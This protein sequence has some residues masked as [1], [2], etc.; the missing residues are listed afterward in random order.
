MKVFSSS[1]L[2][3]SLIAV[4]CVS[5]AV[6]PAT[7]SSD[8]AEA[9]PPPVEAGL[10]PGSRL[11]DPRADE[12]VRQMSDLLAGAHSF[13]LEAE[14][15]YDEV[16]EHSPRIQLTNRR[17]VSLRR[18]DRLAG[19]AS[20]DAVNASFWYDGELFSVLDEEQFAYATLPMPPTIDA[21]L[22]AVFERTGIVIPLM[23]FLHDDVYGRLMEAVERGVYLGI[24]EAAG[25]DCHH[26]AFEQETIDWQLWIDAGDVPLPRKLVIAYKTEGGVPQ[27]TVVIREWELGPE[28]P[29]EL[30]RFEPPEGAELLELPG[31]PAPARQE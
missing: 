27:Y 5:C 16:P 7:L 29:D 10:A 6:E 21:A 12:L 1:Q 8:T 26:L 13:T 19:N 31:P 11:I 3:P 23:D 2:A 9:P 4:A 17:H 24:H 18:P 20:G 28:L 30:F 22:D 15:I 14:E 25:V